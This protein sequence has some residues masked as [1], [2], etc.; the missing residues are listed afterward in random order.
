MDTADILK[1]LTHIRLAVYAIVLIVAVAAVGTM[2]RAYSAIKQLMRKELGTLFREEAQDLLEK[3][4][5]D[6]LVDLANGRIKDRPND[7]DAHWY[8]ARVHRL[9]EEW[10][11]ALKEIRLVGKLAPEWQPK[12]VKPFIQAVEEEREGA[13]PANLPLQPPPENQR[14]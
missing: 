7:V 1:E 9:R 5:L 12:Y 4:A 3:G 14:G 6:K 13:V 8:L 2:V 10:I 11:E